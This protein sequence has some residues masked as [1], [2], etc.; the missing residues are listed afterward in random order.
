MWNEPTLQ[1]LMAMP[2]LYETENVP[3]EEKLIH[4]HFFLGGCDWYAAEFGPKERLLFGYTILNNDRD[5]AEW[6]YFGFDELRD[7]RTK[8][9]YEVD[10]DIYWTPGHAS[11]I[12]KIRQTYLSREGR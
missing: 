4:Q 8:Q 3:P 11:E 2:G 6:G 5:N 7:L 1:E 12:D 10:R 9:G